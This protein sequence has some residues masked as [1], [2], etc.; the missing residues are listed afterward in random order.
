M[1]HFVV[2]C[3]WKNIPQKCCYCFVM[4]Q[5]YEPWI[6]VAG[7]HRQNGVIV[8]SQRLRLRLIVIL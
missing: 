4:K 2:N 6:I 5:R 1:C 7:F 8:H 3:S